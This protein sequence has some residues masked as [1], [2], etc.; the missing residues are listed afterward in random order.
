[1]CQN[2]SC[3]NLQHATQC[4]I[5]HHKEENRIL[6]VKLQEWK[7]KKAKSKV[8]QEKVQVLVE[9]IISTI[10]TKDSSKYNSITIKAC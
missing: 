6:A 7:V 2:R 8:Q 1:M 9:N 10:F 3:T 4:S 5:A